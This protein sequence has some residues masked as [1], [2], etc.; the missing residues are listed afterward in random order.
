MVGDGRCNGMLPGQPS[1]IP[2][3]VPGGQ[4]AGGSGNGCNGPPVPLP[5]RCSAAPPALPPRRADS[6]D[7]DCGARAVAHGNAG[8]G[9]PLRN[10]DAAAAA[11][12][13]K[14]DDVGQENHDQ[15]GDDGD[16]DKD[17]DKW[18]RGA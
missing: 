13:G 8:N 16:D 14:A 1:Q 3:P 12:A 18:G 10:D 4:V 6:D 2:G 7:G 5:P 9:D 15:G 17:D 11:I